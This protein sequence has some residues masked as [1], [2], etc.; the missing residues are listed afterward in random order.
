METD[1][2]RCVVSWSAFLFREGKFDS[3]TSL[4]VKAKEEITYNESWCQCLDPL[5][6]LPRLTVAVHM[7][8]RETR[9]E[10]RLAH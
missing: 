3:L 6:F 9:M 1:V 7:K 4:G 10:V 2:G 8:G 5:A